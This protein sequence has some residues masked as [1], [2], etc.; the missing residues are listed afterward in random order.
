M[1]IL[2]TDFLIDIQ[3]GHFPVIAWFD[4]LRELPSV[5]GLVVMELVQ[6]AKNAQ[7]VRQALKLIAPLPVV[8]QTEADCNHALSYF[9]AYHLL[10]NLG[11]LDSL[12]DTC[13]TDLSATLCTFNV[14]HHCVVPDL[15][16]HN[17]IHDK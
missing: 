9:A 10:D 13:T 3:R 15:L 5:P 6:D 16:R 8:W 1:Y 2:D 7:Q 4:T 17:S 14:K 12:I 11:L